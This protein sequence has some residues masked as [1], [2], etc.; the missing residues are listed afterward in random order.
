[1]TIRLAGFAAQPTTK[2]DT[3]FSLS[4]G[5]CQRMAAVLAGAAIVTVPM[6]AQALASRCRRPSDIPR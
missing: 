4:T 3:M 6:L 1:M 2:G 5:L